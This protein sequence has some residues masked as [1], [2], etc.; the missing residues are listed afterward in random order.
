MATTE[1]LAL[2]IGSQMELLILK[3]ADPEETINDLAQRLEDSG[4]VQPG[5]LRTENAMGFSIDLGSN[6]NLT[7]G[8]WQ[9]PRK[10]LE[11]YRTAED[12]LDAILI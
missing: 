7:V 10:P 5:A 12:L 8:N 3:E 11:K 6:L 2:E 1:E 4:L 9:R